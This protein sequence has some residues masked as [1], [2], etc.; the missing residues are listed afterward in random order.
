MSAAENPLALI[1][2]QAQ[3]IVLQAKWP[4]ADQAAA[5]QRLLDLLC[6]PE[7]NEALM[8]A[9]VIILARGAAPEGQQP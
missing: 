7:T 6:K 1:V 8:R 2:V 9:G 4:G 3:E 5:I